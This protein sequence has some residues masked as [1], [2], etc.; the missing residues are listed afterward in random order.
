MEPNQHTVPP[1]RDRR[2]RRELALVIVACTLALL[3]GALL[4]ACP[5][6]LERSRAALACHTDIR[7]LYSARGIDRGVFPYVDASLRGGREGG[8]LAGDDLQLVGSANEYPV[9]TGLFMWGTGFLADAEGQYLMVSVFLLA[10]F[11]LLVAYLLG[12][13]S[14]LRALL[15]AASPALVL[16][17][18]HSWDLLAVGAATAG[19]WAWWRGRSLLAATLFGIGATL[20][21]YPIL[22]LAPLGLEQ[23]HSGDRRKAISVVAA[24]VAVVALVNLPILI[25]DPDGWLVTYRFHA[26]RPPNYDSLLGVGPLHDLAPRVLNLL[27]TVPLV[28]SVGVILWVGRRRALREGG[29]PFVQVCGAMIAAY[30]LWGKVHSP[31]F[32]LW[33]LPFFA[34]IGLKVR[35][36]VAYMVDHLAL[37]IGFFVLGAFSVRASEL[38]VSM[39]VYVRAAL[40]LVLT[41]LFLRSG[42]ELR[43][44]YAERAHRT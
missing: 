27:M 4:K 14:G 10:P 5:G 11:G 23:W 25:A 3:A 39:T 38:V 24:G 31:Q 42:T 21:F 22:F 37:Y 17:A 13:M 15:W 35:W 18:F 34:L 41:V 1:D 19:L 30:L 43:A 16:Y 9:L 32:A 33:I 12:R 36:W 6:T 2:D 29:Y 28:V 8:R 44:G 26:L 7:T 40:L 20:K